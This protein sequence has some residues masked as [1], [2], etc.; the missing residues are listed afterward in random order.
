MSAPFASMS[1]P[2][3]STRSIRPIE[4]VLADCS[5][6][7]A[8]SLALLTGLAVVWRLFPATFLAGHGQ[9]FDIGDAAQHVS[10]W[11]FYVKDS[12]H[13][14]L[15]HTS[16][17]SFPEGVSIA[18]TDSIPLAALLFKPF[19]AWL[20]A[21]FHYIGLWHAVAFVTQALAAVFLIRSLGV[22]HAWGAVVAAI[23]ALTWPALLFRLGHTSLLT[24]AVVLMA[25]GF[26]VRGRS[27]QWESALQGLARQPPRQSLTPSSQ[28]SMRWTLAAFTVLHLIALLLHPYLLAMAFA[29]FTAWVLD[30]ALTQSA[31]ASTPWP[32]RIAAAL[33]TLIASVA[34]VV[35]AAMAVGYG[36]G[37]T[38]AV[39]YGIYSMNLAAPFCGGRFLDCVPAA[40]SSQPLAAY[41]FVDA[42]TGQ[43]E[44]YNYLGLGLGLILLIALP[45]YARK[46]PG[47]V[48]RSP[49]LF[50]I[51]LAM[52]VYS[53][54]NRIYWQ[55]TE[56][57]SFDLPASLRRLADTFRSSGR[58]FWP[59]GYAVLFLGLAALLRRRSAWAVAVVA[60]ATLL[61]WA[62]TG[63]LRA[64][65]QHAVAAPPVDDLSAWAPLMAGVDTIRLYPPYDCDRTEAAT[66]LHW[67]RMAG[68]YGKTIDTGYISRPSTACRLRAH[69]LDQAPAD[70]TLYVTAAS[71]VFDMPQGFITAAQQGQ[72][73]QKDKVVA[74]GPAVAKLAQAGAGNT[75]VQSLG[76]QN[77]AVQL[78]GDQQ[79]HAQ[80][81]G[82][83]PVPTLP[84][85]DRLNWPATDLPTLIGVLQGDALVPRN[86]AVAG[87]L[88]FGPYAAVPTELPPTNVRIDLDYSSQAPAG[89][90]VGHW[91]VVLGSTVLAEGD[92]SG[93]NGER[94]TISQVVSL[95]DRQ[96]GRLEVRTRF[97]AKGD[98][99]LYG[100]AAAPDRA[101]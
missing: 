29:I 35:L 4:H 65:I 59:V 20:P 69:E 97:D 6:L 13:L 27:G 22:R 36:G 10:G 19:A 51:L 77:T 64:R 1:L 89:Q 26:Y 68:F 90:V 63:P 15:L 56:L 100:I 11:W 58:F 18:F 31:N 95:A 78:T 44:G 39:G 42:T 33:A 5:P 94:R 21:H 76:S 60:A 34:V 88:S 53:L 41:H 46:L 70:K 80:V 99:R 73:I 67:Q 52:A 75:G 93:S 14:P 66:Y 49:A 12:W 28:W 83:K 85:S 30:L 2:A 96:P 8:Y 40:L 37:S 23:F 61:Q 81:A 48:R 17:L 54:S 62:D 3:H 98:L 101:K 7:L 45:L 47:L 71:R 82:A 72:C 92:L 24:H 9:M 38:V 79:A 86:P 91:D 74:C 16:R 25:L 43:Y 32:R 57:L 50:L 87:F 84:L 55:Q